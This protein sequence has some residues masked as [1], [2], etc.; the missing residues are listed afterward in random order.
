MLP[1]CL[2]VYVALARLA[3]TDLA[4]RD[5]IRLATDLLIE[6]LAHQEQPPAGP[7]SQP[8]FSKYLRKLLIE[9]GHQTS[10]LQQVFQMVVQNRELFAPTRA[11][12]VPA[13]INSLTRLGLP[14]NTSLD[15]RF[16][17]VDMAATLLYWDSCASTHHEAADPATS[18]Q[19]DNYRLSSAME[20]MI[21]N[22]LLRMAFI[23]RVGARACLGRLVSTAPL[24]ARGLL[25]AATLET[26]MRP[27]GSAFTRT[28]CAYLE[29]RVSIAFLVSHRASCPGADI[30][31]RTVQRARGAP[32][33]SRLATM[34]GS[35]P[36]TCSNNTLHLSR[37]ATHP[38]TLPQPLCQGCA[39]LFCTWNTTPRHSLSAAQTNLR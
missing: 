23:R 26:V 35:W 33:C 11:Q 21:V 18:K 1:A 13:M 24:T 36:R 7:I 39:W 25:T 9:D 2:Q 32:A 14:G 16:L 20:E 34:R 10:T 27:T 31:K 28:A 30:G 19:P 37:P 17:S 5:A 15:Y 3:P 29:M 38:R 4:A 12:F 8:S 6:T 22:F